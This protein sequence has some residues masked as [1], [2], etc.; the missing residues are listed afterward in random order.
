[1]SISCRRHCSECVTRKRPTIVTPMRNAS[2]PRRNAASRPRSPDSKAWAKSHPTSSEVSSDPT[3][4][5]SPSSCATTSASRNC[6]II[7][8]ARTPWSA[9]SSSSTILGLRMIPIWTKFDD[10][11][12]FCNRHCIQ[13]F[14]FWKH[15]ILFLLQFKLFGISELL[16][17]SKKETVVQL[18]QN[19][20]Q[21]KK[22][23]VSVFL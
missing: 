5:L 4:A 9:R 3:C 20:Q 12:N 23:V 18:L 16:T 19:L 15:H 1:M 10:C 6:W 8:W 11:C 21:L 7:I 2:P 17:L 14:S 13:L 22:I